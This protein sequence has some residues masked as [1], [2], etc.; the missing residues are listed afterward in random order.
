MGRGGCYG[1]GGSC[2]VE[3]LG[4]SGDGTAEF[5][6]DDGV[7]ASAVLPFTLVEGL[8]DAAVGV[9]GVDA[10]VVVVVHGRDGGV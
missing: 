9:L 2:L 8:A 1:E 4:G 5:G 10:E 7:A 6:C 3:L